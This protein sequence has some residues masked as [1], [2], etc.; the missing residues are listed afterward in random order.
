MLQQMASFG[1]GEAGLHLCQLALWPFRTRVRIV[2]SPARTNQLTFQVP[3]LI[4]LGRA[5][6]A[7]S[8]R[9][10]A[11]Q[12]SQTHEVVLQLAPAHGL[13]TLESQSSRATQ[14]LRAITKLK[15][16]RWRPVRWLYALLF[17][18]RDSGSV[19]FCPS[20]EEDTRQRKI[21]EGMV[22][23]VQSLRPIVGRQARSKR[24]ERAAR[25]WLG[26]YTTSTLQPAA[27]RA[28]GWAY[29]HGRLA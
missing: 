18:V 5:S 17:A 13:Q 23:T 1:S 24:C 25:S 8:L 20:C 3:I 11:S 19:R 12:T 14:R 28:Q 6:A 2:C 10:L 26:K 7:R 21:K 9:W 27:I 15:C 29:L 22:D 16:C 4:A